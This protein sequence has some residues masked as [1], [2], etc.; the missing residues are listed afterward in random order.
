MCGIFGAV[1]HSLPDTALENVLH[2]LKH[3]GPDGNGVFVDKSAKVTIGHTR[4]AVIDLTTGAQPIQSQN[5]NVVV[6]CNGEIYEFERIRL[7]LE[8]KGYRF[9]TKSDSEVIIY[10]YEEFGL[11]CF[12]HL[13]GEF[14]FLLY[15][16]AK[17]LLLAG[18]DRFGIKPLYFSRLPAGFVFASE[19]KAIFASGLVAPKLR[20]SA[21]DLLRDQDPENVQ[22]PFEH[23]EH[24]SPASYL[25]VDLD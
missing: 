15:D 2:V 25:T 22:F 12:D 9:K 18:R 1:G 7:S 4:L 5:G 23:I 6:A 13:R 11:N 8:A 24:V 17:R 21:L 14:A 16:K 10:L 3:R 20:I 19:M